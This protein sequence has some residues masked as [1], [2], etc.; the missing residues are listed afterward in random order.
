MEDIIGYL[1]KMQHIMLRELRSLKTPP[2][3]FEKYIK[4]HETNTKNI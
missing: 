3:L 1:I 4:K 2:F